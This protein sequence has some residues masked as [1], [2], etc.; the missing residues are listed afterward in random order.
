MVAFY[1]DFL[2][3]YVRL[4]FLDESFTLIKKVFTKEPVSNSIG[5]GWL[6]RL[7]VRHAEYWHPEPKVLRKSFNWAITYLFIP[8]DIYGY[9]LI[10]IYR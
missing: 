5:F 6:R 10:I 1:Y 8:M 9:I 2:F 3:G 7:R 4:F